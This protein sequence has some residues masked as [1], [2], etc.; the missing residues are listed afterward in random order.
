MNLT[1]FYIINQNVVLNAVQLQIL[2]G[3][4]LLPHK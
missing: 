3:L 4:T 2:R 1:H